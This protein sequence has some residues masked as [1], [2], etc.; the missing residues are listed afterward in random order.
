MSGAELMR[1]IGEVKRGQLDRTRH[2]W[3]P[4]AP[5]WADKDKQELDGTTPS[6]RPSLATWRRRG[7]SVRYLCHR[8]M[9]RKIG[10]VTQDLPRA[11]AP[12][13]EA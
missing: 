8:E 10:E 5:V 4:G 13:D 7:T 1:N 9:V 2:L 3:R 6:W 11:W 12:F